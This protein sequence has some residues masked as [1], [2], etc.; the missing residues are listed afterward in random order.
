MDMSLGDVFY[1][2]C[3]HHK[4]FNQCPQEEEE[5]AAEKKPPWIHQVQINVDKI[6][7]A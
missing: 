1:Q 7:Q 2:C 5:K 4:L 6:A 3:C